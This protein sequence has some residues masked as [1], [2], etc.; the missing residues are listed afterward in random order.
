MLYRAAAVTLV[1]IHA[2]LETAF[3]MAVIAAPVWLLLPWAAVIALPMLWSGGRC[4]LTDL[5]RWLRHRGGDRHYV[6]SMTRRLLHWGSC[7]RIRNTRA[8]QWWLL[9]GA[10]AVIVARVAWYLRLQS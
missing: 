9:G 4:W 1:A 8:W 6:P 3:F 10:G 5:E 2:V 7:G